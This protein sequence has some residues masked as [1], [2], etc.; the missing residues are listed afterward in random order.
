MMMTCWTCRR[1]IV[2]PPIPRPETG[3]TQAAP[4]VCQRCGA[5]YVVT[6]VQRTIPKDPPPPIAPKE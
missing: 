4:M 2:P 3:Y 5:Q 6:V 1:I